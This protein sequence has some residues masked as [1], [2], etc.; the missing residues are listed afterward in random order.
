MN[1]YAKDIE[2]NSLNRFDLVCE[3]NNTSK[4]LILIHPLARVMFENKPY[5]KL[6][7]RLKDLKKTPEETT[8]SVEVPYELTVIVRGSDKSIALVDHD[9]SIRGSR[10]ADPIIVAPSATVFLKLSIQPQLKTPLRDAEV[11]A[12][13]IKGSTEV[14]KSNKLTLRVATDAQP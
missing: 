6:I 1:I 4:R 7:P 11:S 2:T 14:S 5:K 3:I 10:D 12:T 9:V 8:N 13:I